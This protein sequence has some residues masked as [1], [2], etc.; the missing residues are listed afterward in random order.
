M[1]TGNRCRDCPSPWTRP[2]PCPGPRCVTHHRAR[3]RAI[4]ESP[5]GKVTAKRQGLKTS[6]LGTLL[7]VLFANTED[8]WE[9]LR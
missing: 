9:D 3:A 8:P 7:A 1:I 2:A 5:Q 6:Q 4:A